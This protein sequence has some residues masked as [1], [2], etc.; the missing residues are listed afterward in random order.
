MGEWAR[1][2]GGESEFSRNYTPDVEVFQLYPAEREL[3]SERS[4]LLLAATE[5]LCSAG[6]EIEVPL[7][8]LLRTK[9]NLFEVN[10]R[11]RV[12]PHI[13]HLFSHY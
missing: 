3:V 11:E 8:K 13:E 1:F 7:P 12:I 10:A 9:F 2:E 4:T 6:H 5:D